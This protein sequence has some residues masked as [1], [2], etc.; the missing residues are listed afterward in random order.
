MLQY[1][2]GRGPLEVDPESDEFIIIKKLESLGYL[3]RTVKT[4]LYRDVNCGRLGTWPEPIHDT[5]QITA[6][7][8]RVLTQPNINHEII[9]AT[10]SR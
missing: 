10:G 3:S 7:G 8:D 9:R 2:D 1:F 4:G 6:A 5:Y